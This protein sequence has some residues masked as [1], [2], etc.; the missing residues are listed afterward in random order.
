MT[1]WNEWVAEDTVDV[2]L[3]RPAHMPTGNV[4]ANTPEGTEFLTGMVLNV[5]RPKAHEVR[6]IVVMPKVG[7]MTRFRIFF[8]RDPC[9]V[10]FLG[11]DV[12][13]MCGEKHE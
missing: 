4:W 1:I 6:A 9:P 7:H 2:V 13:P 3:D 12:C 11:G 8:E 5:V 10:I